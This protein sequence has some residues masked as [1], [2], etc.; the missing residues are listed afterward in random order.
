M[1]DDDVNENNRR[2]RGSKARSVKRGEF[3]CRTCLPY[4]QEFDVETRAWVVVYHAEGRGESQN[5]WRD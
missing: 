1:C 3:A 2:I 5:I 4:D